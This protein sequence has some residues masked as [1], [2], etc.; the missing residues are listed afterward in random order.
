MAV[1]DGD[2]WVVNGQKVW[3][4]LAHVARYGMLL[5]RTNPDV[6]KH[7]GLVVLRARHAAARASRSARSTR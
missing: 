7:K 4:T 5:V 3:T 1:R 6:P 2:E